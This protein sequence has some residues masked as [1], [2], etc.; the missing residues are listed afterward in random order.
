MRVLF[1]ARH[2]LKPMASQLDLAIVVSLA[3]TTTRY[4]VDESNLHGKDGKR[5]IDAAGA[6]ALFALETVGYT[7]LSEIVPRVELV[8]FGE[9]CTRSWDNG[10]FHEPTGLAIPSSAEIVERYTLEALKDICEKM[11]PSASPPPSAPPFASPVPMSAPP[12]QAPPSPP[13]VPPFYGAAPPAPAAFGGTFIPSSRVSVGGPGP[14]SSPHTM[15]NVVPTVMRRGRF[16][17]GDFLSFPA[18]AQAA[19]TAVSAGLV[20]NTCFA[21]NQLHNACGYNAAGWAM[22]LNRL[23]SDHFHELTCDEAAAVNSQRVIE[24]RNLMLDIEPVERAIWLSGDQLIELCAAYENQ[25]NGPQSPAWLHSP[26]PLNMAMSF[27]HRSLLNPKYHGRLHIVIVNTEPQTAL[28]DAPSGVH[29]FTFAW[30]IEPDDDSAIPATA[31]ANGAMLD[32][33]AE[34]DADTAG[35]CSATCGV[36]RGQ[37]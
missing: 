6:N 12:S 34:G 9:V 5:A 23:G 26:M 10:Y 27:F 4:R 17:I 8:L 11:A 16:W 19:A 13:P 2:N 24:E 35:S 33:V 18:S 22:R 21:A 28:Q 14:S 32:G 25:A 31:A 29:W 20:G 1:L 30:Y 15:A 36:P 37:V 3:L 7:S